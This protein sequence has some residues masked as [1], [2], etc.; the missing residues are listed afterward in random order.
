MTLSVD[1]FRA[2]NFSRRA[3]R[4]LMRGH[5]ETRRH[6]VRNINIALRRRGVQRAPLTLGCI[7]AR[8]NVALLLSVMSFDIAIRMMGVFT[9][10]W[11]RSQARLVLLVGWNWLMS[12]VECRLNFEI[13]LCSYRSWR[14]VGCS[15]AIESSRRSD[16]QRAG[17][18]FVTGKYFWLPI[19]FHRTYNFLCLHNDSII[20]CYRR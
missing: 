16:D 15:A 4:K 1:I 19:N 7:P 6:Q 10:W 8:A 13:F 12:F 14:C 20:H 17:L 9:R 5:G 18:S 2:R 3:R 11:R